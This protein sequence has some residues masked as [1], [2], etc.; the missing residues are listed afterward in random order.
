MAKHGITYQ[1][2]QSVTVKAGEDLPAFRFV[3]HLGTICEADGKALG[4]TEADWLAEEF[5]S[6]ITLGTIPIETATAVNIGD[7]LTAATDGKA[8]PV[9]STEEI[10]GRALSDTPAAGF[11]K[12]LIV[13]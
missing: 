12:M 1:P 8:K 10:N 13:P 6:V 5:A 9:S 2:V 11:V 4:V 3:S 7:A